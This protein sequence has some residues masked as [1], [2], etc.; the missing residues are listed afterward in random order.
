M[1]PRSRHFLTLLCLSLALNA[2]AR[3]LT[4]T[5]W[6]RELQTKLGYGETV[7]GKLNLQLVGNYT[8]PV[9]VL[10]AQTESERARNAFP[11]LETRYDGL[12]KNGQLNLLGD[13]PQNPPVT[14]TKFLSGL[15][16]T[17]GT[18][19]T[20]SLTLPGL[21]VVPPDKNETKTDKK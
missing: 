12:L 3:A 14:L 10:F 21:R 20:P 15:K 7:G 13:E 19:T 16:L 2:P 5:V 4:L 17:P 9:V 8:G 6:D 11:D 1:M 18:W